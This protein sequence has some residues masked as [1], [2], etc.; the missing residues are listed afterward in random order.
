MRSGTITPTCCWRSGLIQ[1]CAIGTRRWIHGA[2]RWAKTSGGSKPKWITGRTHRKWWHQ[3]R[4]RSPSHPNWRW[5]TAT[6]TTRSYR[7]RSSRGQRQRSLSPSSSGTGRQSRD[8]SQNSF[9]HDTLLL[10]QPWRG[11]AAAGRAFPRMRRPGS[12]LPPQRPVSIPR[13]FPPGRTI[14]IVLLSGTIGTLA[15]VA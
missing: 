13:Y 15:P 11:E 5:T 7:S 6:N 3:N 12:R 10:C 14:H 4:R 9:S 1:G 2:R 8:R